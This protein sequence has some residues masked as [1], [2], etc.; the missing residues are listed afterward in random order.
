MNGGTA[1]CHFD[2]RGSAIDFIIWRR[3]FSC[4]QRRAESVAH[5]CSRL[6]V[7]A[8]K[9]KDFHLIRVSESFSWYES[10]KQWWLC[11]HSE[12][13]GTMAAPFILTFLPLRFTP[14]YQPYA[15]NNHR[16][17]K[18]LYEI[19]SIVAHF[20]YFIDITAL[21]AVLSKHI[22]YQIR[23]SLRRL[24][25]NEMSITRMTPVAEP[26]SLYFN[27]NTSALKWGET[28]GIR[29][30]CCGGSDNGGLGEA[31]NWARAWL[32]LHAY[33]KWKFQ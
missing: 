33:N 12:A 30:Y 27:G 18:L 11:Q 6:I 3:A 16:H 10:Q 26:A 2:Y 8:F 7:F 13:A 25:C 29:S 4:H 24:I 21:A 1:W 19:L 31:A 9:G 32:P 23:T 14:Y 20:A 22:K 15:V 17:V 28:T 5:C